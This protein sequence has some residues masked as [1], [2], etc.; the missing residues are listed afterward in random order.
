MFL[1]GKALI[2][3]YLQRAN[4][5]ASWGNAAGSI[6]AILAWLYYSSLIVLFGAELTQVWATKFGR[7][8]RPEHGAVRTIREKRYERPLPN[9]HTQDE[10]RDRIE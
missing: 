7:G 5:G 6:V 4:L 2:A 9:N 3:W 1:I 8:I 10:R